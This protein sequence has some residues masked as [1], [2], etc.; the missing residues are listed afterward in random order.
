MKPEV[1]EDVLA[2]ELVKPKLETEK[3][4]KKDWR[5]VLKEVIYNSTYLQ[6]YSE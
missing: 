5:S 3:I 2:E 1:V 6:M 4:L